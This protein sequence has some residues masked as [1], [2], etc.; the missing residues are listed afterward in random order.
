MSDRPYETNP[1]DLEFLISTAFSMR[2]TSVR[3][4]AFW[5]DN[6]LRSSLFLDLGRM[7]SLV[8]RIPHGLDN[9]KE[10]LE[11]HIHSQGLRALDKCCDSAINVCF[12][13]LLL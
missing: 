9:L 6:C 4:K 10:L 5:K 2:T 12:I 1:G 7:Y 8:H 13:F 3:I 11:E